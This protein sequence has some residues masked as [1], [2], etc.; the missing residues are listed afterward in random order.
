[1]PP[2]TISMRGLDGQFEGAGGG[3]D[4]RSSFGMNGIDCRY[5]DFSERDE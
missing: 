3:D 1:M 5:L 4:A 2:P